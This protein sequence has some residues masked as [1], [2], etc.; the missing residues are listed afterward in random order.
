MFSLEKPVPNKEMISNMKQLES[1]FLELTNNKTELLHELI[2]NWMCLMQGA[3]SIVMNNPSLP[4]Q[5]GKNQ[6]IYISA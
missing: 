5:E 1:T 4:H 2:F 6:E 3:I